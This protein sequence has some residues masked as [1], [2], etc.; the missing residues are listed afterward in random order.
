M[1]STA[2]KTT[3]HG[4]TPEPRRSEC[5][6]APNRC[7]AVHGRSDLARLEVAATPCD[8]DGGSAVRRDRRSARGGCPENA[9]NRKIQITPYYMDP[10][11]RQ[12]DPVGKRLLDQVIPFWDEELEDGYNGRTENWEPSHEMKTPICQHKYDNRVILRMT[13][14]CNAYCQFCSKP[15]ARSTP[16]RTNPPST[17]IIGTPPSPTS[18]TRPRLKKS[19]SA[20]A[21]R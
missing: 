4:Q 11:K 9:K 2:S 3:S 18:P 6:L 15:S 1:H 12:Q 10:I 17:A 5:R 14:V 21:N 13:N 16:R 20:A 7:G 19:S 8:Q